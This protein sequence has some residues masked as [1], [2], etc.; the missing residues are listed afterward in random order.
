MST[1]LHFLIFY[2]QSQLL[3]FPHFVGSFPVG[4]SL[5][6]KNFFKL[7][8]QLFWKLNTTRICRPVTG[9]IISWERN[10]TFLGKDWILEALS[11]HKVF[12]Q[13]PF[14]ITSFRWKNEASS[15]PLDTIKF[16]NAH[17]KSLIFILK[18]EKYIVTGKTTTICGTRFNEYIKNFTR[19][20]VSI[21]TFNFI[22]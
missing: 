19:K 14:F 16:N 1:L 13:T 18:K 6:K 15:R 17:A 9:H 2:I 3:R 8:E 22:N 12:H 7:L 20:V 4:Y 10:R 5:E 11:Q 21:P